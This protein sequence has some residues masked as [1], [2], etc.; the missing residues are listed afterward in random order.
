MERQLRDAIGAGAIG[1]TTSWASSHALPDGRPVAS[2][3]SAWNETERLV[4]VT[5]EARHALFEVSLPKDHLGAD[6]EQ[7]DL[8]Y[9][10]M[11]S[12]ALA[13][14]TTFMFGLTA[15][16]N[17]DDQQW[18]RTLAMLE[19]TNAAGGRMIAQ[20]FSKEV[21]VVLSFQTQLPFDRLEE[22]TDLRSLPLKQQLVQLRDPAVRNTLVDAAVHGRYDKPA[23]G[24]E[25]PAPDF[26]AIR[27]MDRPGNQ[28]LTLAEVAAQRRCHPVDAMIDLSLECD[29]ERFFYQVMGNTSEAETLELLR[30][31]NS[32]MTFSDSGAHVRQ[33]INSSIQTHL[34]S[35]WVRERGEFTLEEAV[36]MLTL[37]PAAIWQFS[38]RGLIRQGMVADINIID[39]EKVGASSP[40]VV[41]D[42]PGGAQRLVERST[43]IRATLVSGEILLRD[44]EHTGA[45]PGKLLRGAGF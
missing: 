26:Y 30:H 42:F 31:P 8:L 43:G 21:G 27:L 20:T 12:L 13:T 40:T 17:A 34:L 28:N 6:P 1:F 16:R 32:V 9:R 44:N 35:Y 5:G 45:L 38:D 37:V 39:P 29:L 33:L 24:A 36:R 25:A 23:L 22:W 19:A 2:R 7:D 15:G 14:G 18:R 4:G 3:I 41:S 10:K 11:R